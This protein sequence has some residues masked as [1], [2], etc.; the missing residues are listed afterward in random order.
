MKNAGIRRNLRS[1]IPGNLRNNT[2]I[3]P[4]LILVPLRPFEKSRL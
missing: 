4:R 3:L 2:D 1:R